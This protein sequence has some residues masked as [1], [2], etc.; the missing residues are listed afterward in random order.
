MGAVSVKYIMAIGEGAG[1]KVVATWLT[2]FAGTT[3]SALTYLAYEERRTRDWLSNSANLIDVAMAGAILVAV[4]WA[5][6]S[7]LPDFPFWHKV[8]LALIIPIW[9]LW[10]R[11]DSA[12]GGY[13]VAQ[14]MLTIGYFPQWGT[15]WGASANAEPFMIWYTIFGISLLAA[16]NGYVGGSVAS[17]VYGLRSATVVSI[18][19]LLMCRLEWYGHEM[20]G[21]AITLFALPALVYLT[22]IGWW[23]S[24]HLRE[25][26]EAGVAWLLTEVF[27]LPFA[28]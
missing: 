26:V 5:H 22:L 6:G 2:L 11:Q 25:I 18:G 12:M 28:D 21:F 16:L 27:H 24:R 1:H 23:L 13:A 7:T 4:L 10:W 9:W 15:Q 17:M 20:G 3:L 14:C 8:C 19:L